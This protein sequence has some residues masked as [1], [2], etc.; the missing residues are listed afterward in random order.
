MYPKL[1][2]TVPYTTGPESWDLGQQDLSRIQP[3]PADGSVM[4]YVVHVFSYFVVACIVCSCLYINCS[5]CACVRIFLILC[6]D[7]WL[8]EPFSRGEICTLCS[9]N[10]DSIVTSRL[11]PPQARKKLYRH[12]HKQGRQDDCGESVFLPY[13][14]SPFD[15]AFDGTSQAVLE[16]LRKLE[17]VCKLR[18]ITGL[19]SIVPL[20][21]T[22][23]SLSG[24]QQLTG[25]DKKYE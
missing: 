21:L 12:S 1:H 20:Q 5:V 24:Y 6:W 23:G 13:H 19:H 17:M 18:G 11:P 7:V 14:E 2:Y 9:M 25:S 15:P 3:W 22:G 4:L 16:W 10:K 8:S